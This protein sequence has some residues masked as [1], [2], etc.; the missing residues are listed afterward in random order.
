V[1]KAIGIAAC[2]LLE[3]CRSEVSL[4][5]VGPDISTKWPRQD[6][7]PVPWVRVVPSKRTLALKD[8]NFTTI[9]EQ[10][11]YDINYAP[12]KKKFERVRL[13]LVDYTILP[14]ENKGL[15]SASNATTQAQTPP[16]SSTSSAPAH[17]HRKARHSSSTS[18]ASTQSQSQTQ[19]PPASSTPS[20]PTQGQGQTPPATSAPSASIQD[21]GQILLASLVS[22]APAQDPSQTPPA[23]SAPNAVTQAQTPPASSAP[24]AAAQAQTPPASS[25]PNA[26]AQAQ[27]PPASSAPN[28]AAQAQTPPA[29]SAPNAAAQAQ[30]PPASP[31][32]DATAQAQPASSATD[33]A[34]PPAKS[35]VVN[36][37]EYSTQYESRPKRYVMTLSFYDCDKLP[38]D[39]PIMEETIFM[40]TDKAPA[41]EAMRLLAHSVME[42]LHASNLKKLQV[43]LD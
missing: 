29:P 17:G 38:P 20:A 16:A 15:L 7:A 24:N 43:S 25:A 21:K 35:M 3:G 1:K 37:E 27:T 31:A 9:A 41:Q 33:K 26:A 5:D 23:P 13:V 32:P 4:V 14:H 40:R 6:T 19:T 42:D 28:A 11:R 8:V 2:L 10:I 36:N 22:S 39:A 12:H 18:S 34:N 30:T